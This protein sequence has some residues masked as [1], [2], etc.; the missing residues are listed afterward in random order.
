MSTRL[1]SEGSS[2]SSSLCDRMLTCQLCWLPKGAQSCSASRQPS[3]DSSSP[4]GCNASCQ[5]CDWKFLEEEAIYPAKIFQYTDYVNRTIDWSDKYCDGSCICCT[6]CYKQ[7]AEKCMKEKADMVANKVDD[8]DDE[9][10]YE[11]EDDR[12]F[13]LMAYGSVIDQTKYLYG[14][15]DCNR[16]PYDDRDFALAPTISCPKC[17]KLTE[18][19]DFSLNGLIKTYHSNGKIKSQGEYI[20][21][22]KVGTHFYSTYDNHWFKQISYIRGV[23]HG[24]YQTFFIDYTTHEQI[25]MYE[26]MYV[27]G[28]KEGTETRYSEYGKVKET[29]NY[30]NGLEDGVFVTYTINGKKE[31][32]C[33]YV[34]GKRHGLYQ[35]WLDHKLIEECYYQEGIKVKTTCDQ[36]AQGAAE[37]PRLTT[38]DQS[39]QGAAEAPRR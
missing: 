22:I 9:D 29:G 20:R 1:G 28:K 21:G 13:M 26:V 33:E 10:D 3:C 14:G 2:K 27:D 18:Y 38:C 11:N 5:L 31:S 36:S 23:K 19:I 6:E 34:C 24:L 37:A 15:N 4:E 30:I 7:H 25:K 16:I 35:R 8:K 12:Y 39:A 32:S 17:K